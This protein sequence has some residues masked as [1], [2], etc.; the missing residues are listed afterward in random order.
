V[1]QRR[2]LLPAGPGAPD[3]PRA[4]GGLRR[5]GRPRADRPVLLPLLAA[6]AG[7][8]VRHAAPRAPA[9][10]LDRPARHP[11]LPVV[12]HLAAAGAGARA[13]LLYLT[14]A[15]ALNY[16]GWWWLLPSLVPLAAAQYLP[17]Y[18]ALAYGWWRDRR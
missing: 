16:L 7:G 10:H 3:R 15:V 9:G 11:V 4:G 14:Y 1:H 12:L 13:G 6:R 5:G 18:A 8:R 17:T 2:P